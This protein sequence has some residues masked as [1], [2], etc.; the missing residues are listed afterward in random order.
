MITR[1]AMRMGALFRE[2]RSEDPDLTDE[3]LGAVLGVSQVHVTNLRNQADKI[4]DIKSAL[5]VRVR[6][7]YAVHSDYFF[8]DYEGFRSYHR[9]DVNKLRAFEHRLSE[10]EKRAPKH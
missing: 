6:E 1:A 10:L 5:I 3:K 7:K 2:L 4:I 8:D 9:Y